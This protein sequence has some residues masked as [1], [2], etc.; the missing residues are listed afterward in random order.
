ML[1]E[2]KVAPLISTLGLC[3]Q[4]HAYAPFQDWSQGGTASVCAATSEAATL[5]AITGQ[6]IL[7]PI[8]ELASLTSACGDLDNQP[9]TGICGDQEDLETVCENSKVTV[10][11][12]KA[13]CDLACPCSTPGSLKNCEWL[14]RTV[15]RPS[16]L[17]ITFAPPA[18]RPIRL[19]RV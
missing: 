13:A 19:L 18:C 5:P 15:S 6:D 17:E 16:P 1:H 10:A 3:A 9:V 7:F 11:E 4:V 14:C 8:H 12:A 2:R